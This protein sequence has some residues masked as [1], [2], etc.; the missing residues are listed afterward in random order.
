MIEPTYLGTVG[1]CS[2][3]FL[4][5]ASRATVADWSDSTGLINVRS[6]KPLVSVPAHVDIYKFYDYDSRLPGVSDISG[7]DRLAQW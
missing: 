1:T 2:S 6:R 4:C 7:L 5:R 3:V